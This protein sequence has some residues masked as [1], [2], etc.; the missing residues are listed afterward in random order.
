LLLPFFTRSFC[1]RMSYYDVSSVSRFFSPLV[2]GGGG[3]LFIGPSLITSCVLSRWCIPLFPLLY[4]MH[5]SS[6]CRCQYQCLGA[7]KFSFRD[8]RHLFMVSIFLLFCGTLTHS[9]HYWTIVLDESAVG[10]ASAQG[11]GLGAGDQDQPR[12]EYRCW[13]WCWYWC[14][15]WCWCRCWC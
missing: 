3:S 13:C 15:C 12:G 5:T 2:G 14:W 10:Q 6:K 1:V 9:T 11:L 4:R 7:T 8:S